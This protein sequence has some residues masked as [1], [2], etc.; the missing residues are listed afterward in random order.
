LYTK[1]VQHADE[2]AFDGQRWQSMTLE[3][4]IPKTTVPFR[5]TPVVGYYTL[6]SVPILNL[7][8]K[9]KIGTQPSFNPIGTT[10]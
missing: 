3:Y 10:T 2:V 6:E 8:N 4:H 9:F 1:L 7:N 5:S